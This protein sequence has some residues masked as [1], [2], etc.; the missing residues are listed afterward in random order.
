M[1]TMR[2]RGVASLAAMGLVAAA[3]A[4]GLSPA[5]RA[6]GSGPQRSTPASLLRASAPSAPRSV[7][8]TGGNGRATLKWV[9]PLHTNGSAINAYL[10]WPYI[11]KTQYRAHEFHSKK[12]S[13]V[14]TGLS[15]GRQYTFRVAARNAVGIGPK[16][17]ASP[18]VSVRAPTAAHWHPPSSVSISW[19]WQL[20]TPPP[21]PTDTGVQ[22]F[23]ID[24]FDTS[25]A[26]VA[27]LHARGTKVICYMDVGSLE[28]GRPDDNLIPSKD[29]GSPVQGFQSERWLNIADLNGLKAMIV[30]RLTICKSRG[31]DAVEPDNVDGYTNMTGFPLTAQEQLTFNI[32]VANTAHDLGLSVGLKN[33]VG[34][35]V[36]LQP[37]F[38]WALNE[39]CNFFSECNT[40]N[41]FVHANKAVFNAEYSD[42]GES[43]DQFCSAD[44]AAHINGVLFDLNLAGA[45][46]Q[47]CSG[48]W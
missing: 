28:P 9:A 22:V 45:T 26:T 43:T 4:V 46:Y 42:D 32:F 8:A 10:V 21:V 16:S 35:T 41:P 23:D 17:S 11:G 13:E 24:G 48:G 39:E 14:I 3:I 1:T 40:E 38:D 31:F 18:V 44:V 34:Q 33:D 30:H 20:T 7:K 47:P 27:A 36:Q 25:A 15:N 19:N 5:P 6:K 12:T 29:V 37:Y 2:M